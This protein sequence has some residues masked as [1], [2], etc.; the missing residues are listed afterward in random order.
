MSARSYQNKVV[1]I[2]GG[3]SGIGFAMAKIIAAQDAQL[4]LIARD[5]V[6]L[7]HQRKH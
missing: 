2:T 3:S 6:N 1:V 5:E 4:V 7:M